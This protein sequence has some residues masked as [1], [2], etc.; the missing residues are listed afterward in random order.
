MHASEGVC[1]GQ[2]EDTWS[3]GGGV[4]GSCELSDSGCW[5]LNPH[6]LQEWYLL[7]TAEASLQPQ[8]SKYSYALVSVSDFS[9]L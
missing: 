6:P 3:P 9:G 2:K 8:A 7:L 5:D 4:T 1:V